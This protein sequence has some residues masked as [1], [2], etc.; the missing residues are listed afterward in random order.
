[1]TIFYNIV[2]RLIIQRSVTAHVD[3]SDDDH[4]IRTAHFVYEL[5]LLREH[6]LV[7]PNNVDLS[8]DELDQLSLHAR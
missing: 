4:H 1:M 5:I 7:L 8:R 2:I 6:D 3:N